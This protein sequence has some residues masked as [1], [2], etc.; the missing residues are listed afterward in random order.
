MPRLPADGRDGLDQGARILPLLRTRT[1]L[2]QGRERPRLTTKNYL[3]L[4]YYFFPC[5]LCTILPEIGE[6][7]VHQL[8]VEGLVTGHAKVAQGDDGSVGRGG[9]L[10]GKGRWWWIEMAAAHLFRT[11]GLGDLSWGCSAS[12]RLG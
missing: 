6:Q 3:L 10:A 5:Y 4:L 7:R 12:S 1:R 9:S 2:K 8:D 11:A